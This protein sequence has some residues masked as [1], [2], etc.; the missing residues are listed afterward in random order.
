[1]KQCNL[2]KSYLVEVLSLTTKKVIKSIPV[3]GFN[4]SYDVADGFFE[5]LNDDT[6]CI[7]ITD[8]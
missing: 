1:M 4:E 5:D 3:I 8:I 7:M 6:E 2:F